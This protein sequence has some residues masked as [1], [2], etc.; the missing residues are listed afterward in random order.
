MQREGGDGWGER[1]PPAS[2]PRSPAAP[3][4]GGEFSEPL[5][6]LSRVRKT[7]ETLVATNSKKVTP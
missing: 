3:Q 2:V 4:P 7:W 1:P 6:C 5:G